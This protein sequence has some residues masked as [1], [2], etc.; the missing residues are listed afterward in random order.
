MP[1]LVAIVAACVAVAAP[2]DQAAPPQ[3]AWKR[4]WVTDT[5]LSVELPGLLVAG[6]ETEAKDGGWVKSAADFRYDD[7]SVFVQ[8]TVFRGD[9]ATK[10][11]HRLLRDV[12][13]QI[14]DGMA[15]PGSPSDHE[16]EAEWVD[17]A[18]ALADRLVIAQGQTKFFLRATL[19]ADTG[20]VFAVLTV[21]VDDDGASSRA[22]G[23]VHGSVRYVPAGS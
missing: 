23:R 9:P 11:S 22:A 19:V 8:V 20:L 6:S 12:W 5:K 4:Q 10:P 18:P 1:A 21:A 3:D 7:D 16:P 14:R 17:D 2:Q 15:G 13:A